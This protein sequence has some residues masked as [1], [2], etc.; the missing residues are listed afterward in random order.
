MMLQGILTGKLTEKWENMKAGPVVHSRWT[1]TQ[2]RTLRLYMSTDNPSFA[3]SRLCSF[4]VYVYGPVFLA[5]IHFHGAEEGSRILLQEVKAVR[6]HCLEMEL[7]IIQPVIKTN[8]FFG[9]GENVLISLLCSSAMED[10][11][12]AV[13][14][15]KDIRESEKKE[16]KSRARKKVRPF[17]VP[18]DLNFNAESISEL[19]DLSLLKTEPPLTIQMTDDQLN[20]IVIH[21]LKLGLPSSTVAVER[22]VKMTTEAAKHTSDPILQDGLSFQK[23]S[24]RTKNSLTKDR[25]KKALKL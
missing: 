7:D 14:V 12:Y 23:I 9:H 5:A 17:K 6:L 16:K 3:L 11:E 13:N 8:G 15:I 21:P 1:N 10:R 18:E 25:N 19:T 20:D 24:A 2:S 22:G 4:I